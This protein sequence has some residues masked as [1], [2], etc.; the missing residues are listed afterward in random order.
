MTIKHIAN[1][2]LMTSAKWVYVVLCHWQELTSQPPTVSEIARRAM[3]DRKTVGNSLRA[4]KK[5]GY[6]E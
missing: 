1:S 4:L 3:L 5:A 2:P 6:I